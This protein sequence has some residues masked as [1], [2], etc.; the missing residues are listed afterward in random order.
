MAIEA[1]RIEQKLEEL[2]L[3][4]WA[5]AV[6]L[7]GGFVVLTVF[8]RSEVV[9]FLLPAYVREDRAYS[10]LTQSRGSKKPTKKR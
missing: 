8:V 2:S 1:W 7:I 3:P 6:V 10:F 5:S 9:R 4:A